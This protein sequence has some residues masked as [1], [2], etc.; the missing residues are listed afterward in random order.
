MGGNDL[1]KNTRADAC[2]M[3]LDVDRNMSSAVP[4]KRKVAEAKDIR[5]FHQISLRVPWGRRTGSF[6]VADTAFSKPFHDKE[7]SDLGRAIRGRRVQ[8][9]VGKEAESNK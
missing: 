7:R 1:V 2:P 9:G 4:V 6:E 3:C 5:V 8:I